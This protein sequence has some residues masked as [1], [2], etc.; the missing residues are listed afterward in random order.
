M[1]EEIT[2]ALMEME[3]ALSAL[4]G[5]D[6]WMIGTC[7]ARLRLCR[8]RKTCEDGDGGAGRYA[9]KLQRRGDSFA[10]FR[11]EREG[12]GG[13]SLQVLLVKPVSD[14]R[15]EIRQAGSDLPEKESEMTVRFSG[16]QIDNFVKAV[17]DDNPIHRGQNA[18]VP[19]FLM[20][21]ELAAGILCGGD[22]RTDWDVIDADLDVKFRSPLR[23][24]EMAHMEKQTRDD[25]G[26]RILIHAGDR[27]LLEMKLKAEYAIKYNP[28]NAVI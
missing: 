24:E 16:Q 27:L 4:D 21:N 26:L 28:K 23:A 19:G 22:D 15:E 2:Q 6:G 8:I 11:V 7:R 18:V 13:N 20:M 9:A 5:F 1:R 10:M 14:I 3:R 12:D 25:K 17:S